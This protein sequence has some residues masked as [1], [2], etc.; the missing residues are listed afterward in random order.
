MAHKLKV[1]SKTM[2]PFISKET[3]Q[4]GPHY[5]GLLY[6]TTGKKQ[7]AIYIGAVY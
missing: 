2:A 1:S 6:A 3:Q 5:T 4:Y 7:L